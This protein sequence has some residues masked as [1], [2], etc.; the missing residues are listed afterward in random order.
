MNGVKR[1]DLIEKIAIKLQS[2]YSGNQ[3]NTLLAGYGITTFATSSFSASKKIHVC[4]LLKEIPNETIIQIASDLELDISDIEINSI[5]NQVKNPKM[6]KKVFISHSSI[7]KNFAG[8]MIELLEAMGVSSNQIFCSSFEGYGIPLGEQ[9]LERI[10]NELNNEVLVLFILSENFYNSP[11]CLCEMGATW[12]KTNNHIPILI[13]PFEF[14]DV[15]GVIPKIQGMKINE[16]VK[17]NLLK[18]NVESFFEIERINTSAWERKRDKIHS[19]I[20]KQLKLS[21]KTHP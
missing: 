3:I 19:E 17:W 13:P 14:S 10:K 15:K 18:E 8:N 1:L 20:T 7:D 5:L 12:V 9:F 11:I 2:A 16:K 4:N 21:S 6:E